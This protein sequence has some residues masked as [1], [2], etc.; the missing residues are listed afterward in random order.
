MSE[1]S[2]LPRLPRSNKPHSALPV[3]YSSADDISSLNRTS[4]SSS[5]DESPSESPPPPPR[6]E[7]RSPRFPSSRR[8][9]NSVDSKSGRSG[10]ESGSN[11]RKNLHKRESSGSGKLISSPKPTDLSALKELCATGV[12][13][14]G[15]Y[16]NAPLNGNTKSH[17]AVNCAVPGNIGDSC[18]SFEYLDSQKRK[19]LSGSSVEKQKHSKAVSPLSSGKE[20]LS[21]INSHAHKLFTNGPVQKVASPN[22]PHQRDRSNDEG[23]S[24]HSTSNRKDSGCQTE[25]SYVNKGSRISDF[26]K[27]IKKLLERQQLPQVDELAS[28]QKVLSVM[29]KLR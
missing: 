25:K 24:T 28:V 5:S 2:L 23:S 1:T 12:S 10:N 20:Q 29:D 3:P 21:P 14:E 19:E 15:I 7:T 9:N 17:V 22:A 8:S 11:N 13:S 27:E 4:S 16:D 6:D 18:T 26:E